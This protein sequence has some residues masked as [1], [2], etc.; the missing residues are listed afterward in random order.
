MEH[1]DPVCGMMVEEATPH[2]SR[3]G[4]RTV[5]FCSESCK[6]R[7]DANPDHYGGAEKS[8]GPAGHEAGGHSSMT[9]KNHYGRL[10]VMTIVSFGAMYVLMYAIV[11]RLSNV[12]PNFNQIYMAGLMTAGM[13]VIELLLMGGMYPNRRLNVLFIGVSLIAMAAFFAFIRDQ[14]A[15]G[16][17]QFLKSMIPHH[18]SAILM[19]QQASIH[20][21]QIQ[22]LCAEIVRGQQAEIDQMKK[23]LSEL[24]K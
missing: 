1:T 14:T 4:E 24:Q 12:Y 20:D 6:R 2:A 21:P 11:D 15:V 10:L 5:Y 16:D 7:F 17:R 13:V 9:K 18:A 23:R 3:R 19:C 22:S 8:S